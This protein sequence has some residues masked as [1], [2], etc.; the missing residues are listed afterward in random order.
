MFKYIKTFYDFLMTLK[1][2]HAVHVMILPAFAYFIFLAW[3]FLSSGG[4]HYEHLNQDELHMYFFGLGLLIFFQFAIAYSSFFIAI[5]VE[6]IILIIQFFT[7][8]KIL[9]KRK[10]ILKSPLYNI[11][12]LLSLAVYLI[13]SLIILIDMLFGIFQSKIFS[14]SFLVNFIGI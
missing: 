9:I 12:F 4:L 11:I 14:S 8:Q 2:Y 7:H 13:L 6:I 3:L 1:Q 10:F 5:F